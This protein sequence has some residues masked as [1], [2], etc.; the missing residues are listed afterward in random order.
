MFGEDQ[1]IGL[2][3]DQADRWLQQTSKRKANIAALRLRDAGVLVLA[4]N[5]YDNAARRIYHQS[6]P[7]HS[8][9]VV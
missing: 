6:A 2:V 4:A 7:L 3:V 1:P 5:L 8:G 9:L